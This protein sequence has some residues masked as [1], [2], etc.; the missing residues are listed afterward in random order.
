MSIPC[1]L[2]FYNKETRVDSFPQNVS[3][4]SVQTPF[5]YVQSIFDTIA[6]DNG[7]II[8]SNESF[9]TVRVR[10]PLDSKLYTWE[11]ILIKNSFRVPEKILSRLILD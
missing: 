4:G 1:G 11:A 6:R 10:W 9:D 8:L 5:E 3:Y 7:F 2:N